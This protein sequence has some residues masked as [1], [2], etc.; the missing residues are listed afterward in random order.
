V[1]QAR[2]RT[3]GTLGFLWRFIGAALLMGTLAGGIAPT[4]A[5]STVR[6][7][8]RFDDPSL[9]KV[10]A[11]DDVKASLRQTAGPHGHALCLDYDFGDVSGYAV[12]RRELALDYPENYE[13]SFAMRGDAAPNTLQFKLLDASGENVWWANR[14]DFI[15][16]RDWE[17][18]RFRPRHLSFAWGP[19]PDQRLRRTAALEFVIVRGRGGGRGTVCFDDLSF[20]ELPAHAAPLQPVVQASSSAPQAQP[21]DAMDG[22][23]GTAWRSVPGRG[24]PQ[25]ITLDFRAPREFSGLILH[26]VP[27][28]F[29]TRYAIESSDDG[30]RWRTIRRVVSG[31]G[32]AD[33]H[34][35]PESE[36]RYLRVRMQDGPGASYGI[37]EIEVKD[38][39]WSA[40]PNDFFQNLA[41]SALRGHYP[42]AYVREQSY[43][44][45]L[46]V[47]GGLHHGL[48]SEDGA[49]EIAPQSAS[50]EP[51]L[52]DGDRLISWADI[53][54]EHSLQDDYLPIPTVRWRHPQWAL[55]VTAFAVGEPGRAHI[56]AHYTVQNRAD[57]HRSV[58]LL[59]AVR[60]FQVNP[61]PQFL[62]APGGVTSLREIEW[63]GKALVLDGARKLHPLHAPDEVRIADFD[64]GN[65]PEGPAR[66]GSRAPSRVKDETG[67]AS[68]VL[69]YRME[70]PP[71]GSRRIAIV[72]PLD[73]TTAVAAAD[74]ESWIDRQQA[75]TA[76][77]WREKLNRTRLHLPD[78]AAPLW[79]TLRTALAHVLIG[80]AGPALQPGTRAYARSWI[81]DG[82]MMSDALLRLGH[83]GVPRG[84]IEW[85]APHQ[86]RNGKVP[87]CVDHRGADP[88]AENDSHG[89]LIH[90]IAQHHRYRQDGAWLEKMWPRVAAAAE[91]MNELRVSE[92]TAQN[93]A[94]ARRAFYGLMP[95]SISHEGYSDKP[96]Y[97]YWDDFWTLAGYDAAVEMADALGRHDVAERYRAWR[98]EFKLDLAASLGASIAQHRIDFIPGAADR[99]DY[100]PTSTTIGLSIAGMQ[101]QLPQRELRTTFERYWQEFLVRRNSDNWEAYTPYEWRNVGAFA[102]LGWRDRIPELIAFFMND[103]RPSAW[104]QWAE[105]VGRSVRQPRFIGDMPHGWVASDYISAVLD[106]FAY[107]RPSDQSVVLAAGMSSEW[108]NEGVGIEALQT[109]FGALT[110]GFRRLGDRLELKIDSGITPPKGGLVI[111]WPYRG[112]PGRTAVNGR[113]AQWENERELRVFTVPASIVMELPPEA[114]Q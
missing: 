96:A 57:T 89:A 26:W 47:D 17:R 111:A 63:D 74:E 110:Y 27:D 35:L 25:T 82:A 108:L 62:N 42:R 8:D 59:L 78:A 53:G 109:P 54:V 22:A 10:S 16:P 106:L 61:P 50:I 14:P 94:A 85:F 90:A 100:D 30:V 80:R 11:S 73:G 38:V 77:L 70:L 58:A 31:N 9:W 20:R 60:P 41:S 5:Q 93:Q 24:K 99:G 68:G 18:I 19:A 95:P 46:G 81:R 43:W 107:E 33:P 12:A 98:N 103:R 69:I 28:G 97:S 39:A 40:T 67:F 21:Q 4:W 76:A 44:T 55:D 88:V 45:I 66:S 15:F 112:K 34:H 64:A 83:H 13:F 75:A 92:R 71:R 49:L 84:Y 91:Y 102:R 105:V 86:F 32:G 101:E 51:F 104:N 37:A 23:M 6:V 113:P 79:N 36:A 3:R 7:L 65:I 29:A 114:R 52:L 87:C 1:R 56:V 72:A 2:A 48:L